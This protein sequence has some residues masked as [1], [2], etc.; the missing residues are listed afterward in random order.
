MIQTLSEMAE[1][2]QGATVPRWLRDYVLDK[3]G[4]IIADLKLFGA[5][6]IYGPDGS[7]ITITLD[8]GKLRE[9]HARYPNWK[10]RMWNWLRG[11]K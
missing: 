2:I 1:H 3:R 11:E 5:H 8:H 4:M 7:V 10:L 6:E 9:A